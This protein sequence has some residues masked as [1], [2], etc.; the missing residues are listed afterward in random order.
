MKDILISSIRIK[1]ELIT[2]SVCF[3]I[4]FAANVG[5]I[6]FYKSTSVELV[7]SL[8]YVLVFVFVIYFIWSFLRIIK[9][10]VFKKK[11]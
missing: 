9:W 10:L 4:G 5:A 2:L 6:I 7:T 11:K 8:P 1:K 3:L